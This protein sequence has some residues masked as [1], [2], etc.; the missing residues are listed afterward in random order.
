MRPNFSNGLTKKQFLALPDGTLCRTPSAEH[1]MLND[2][3]RSRMEAVY[4]DH[5]YIELTEVMVIASKQKIGELPTLYKASE[6]SPGT[7]YIIQIAS[8]GSYEEHVS[9]GSM[10]SR[11]FAPYGFKAIYYGPMY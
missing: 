10:H 9:Y 2:A 1:F 7:H 5:P 4:G 8:D 6:L 11:I 3:S